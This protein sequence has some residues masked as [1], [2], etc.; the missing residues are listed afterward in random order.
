[1]T[2]LRCPYCQHVS[3]PDRVE[4]LC[5]NCGK[6]FVVPGKLRKTTFRERQRMRAEITRDVDRQRRALAVP[7][8]IRPGRNPRVLGAII[9]CLVVLGSL[10]VG[11]ANRM[12][13]GG[14]MSQGF[15]RESRAIRELAALR[16]ALDRFQADI[17]RYPDASEGLKALVLNPGIPGWGGNYVSVVKPDPWRMPYHYTPS[18][19]GFD[20]RSGGPDRQPLTAD[21]ILPESPT[22]TADLP[23]APQAVASPQ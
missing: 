21:D 14:E 23:E 16:T 20:L 17:G 8:E 7:I 18:P 1:M 19:A 5:S 22:Q 10:L 6:A 4:G 13:P 9:L 3:A 12:A 2:R 15:S 11:R